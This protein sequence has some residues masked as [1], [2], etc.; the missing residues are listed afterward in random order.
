MGLKHLRGA[1]W[2]V[3]LYLA[4]GA[5]AQESP[6]DSDNDGKP[7]HTDNCPQNYGSGDDGCPTP[8]DIETVIVVGERTINLWT[9]RGYTIDC[10]SPATAWSSLCSGFYVP[11]NG[12]WYIQSPR[13]RGIWDSSW[14]S[15]N[16]GIRCGA[17]EVPK[18]GENQSWRCVCAPGHRR[19]TGSSTSSCITNA[20]FLENLGPPPTCECGLTPSVGFGGNGIGPDTPTWRCPPEH[21]CELRYYVVPAGCRLAVAGLAGAV[22][23]GV[24][25]GVGGA[26]ICSIGAEIIDMAL[27]T[28]PAIGPPMTLQD[29]FQNV[30]PGGDDDL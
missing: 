25:L 29:A 8:A 22:C 24:G 23:Y 16:D 11:R 3:C 17:S 13:Y 28:C 30:Q 7:D 21:V 5:L 20:Q 1:A 6:P 19:E 9:T 18:R 27:D 12:A 4:G 2:A 10:T 15:E 26:V 14:T